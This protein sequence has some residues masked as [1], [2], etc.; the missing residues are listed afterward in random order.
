MGISE[1]PSKIWDKVSFQLSSSNIS[2]G[3][4][5]I[6]NVSA[7][8]AMLGG[9]FTGPACPIVLTATATWW[10]SSAT[11]VAS[12]IAFGAQATTTKK[13]VK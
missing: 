13:E 12:I 1:V 2:K 9:I 10:I 5:I 4:K 8:V 6:R 7:I 11:T 3:W